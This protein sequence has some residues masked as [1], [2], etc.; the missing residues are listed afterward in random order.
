LFHEE[1]L[2]ITAWF[3]SSPIT[4]QGTVIPNNSGNMDKDILFYKYQTDINSSSLMEVTNTCINDITQFN[5]I[6]TYDSIIWDFDDPTSG[7]DNTS[8]LNN[9]SHIFTNI[10]TYNVTAEVTCGTEVEIL[11]LE[12]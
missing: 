6:G 7:A 3:S 9:P 4:I 12:V 1:D 2:Y 11:D 5:L 8:T 10:G